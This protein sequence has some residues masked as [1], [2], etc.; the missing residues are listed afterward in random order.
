MKS[1]L[2]IL[3]K[4]ELELTRQNMSDKDEVLFVLVGYDNQSLIAFHDR[5]LIVK[6]GM[7]AGTTFGGRATTFYYR[8]ITNIEINTGWVNAVL[9]I[10]TPSFSGGI[11]KEFFSRSKD[12]NPYQAANCIPFAKKGLAIWQPFINQ[13]REKSAEAKKSSTNN[14]IDSST[15]LA[16][17]LE[18]L[19]NLNRNGVLTDEE[20][21]KAKNKL[22]DNV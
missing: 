9:E 14:T 2:E 4:N 13:I 22:L 21:Q 18:K 11:Q 5:V 20:F 10:M 1:P 6:T 16:S 8:D 12:S 7:L 3:K 15:D 17:Q 19:S